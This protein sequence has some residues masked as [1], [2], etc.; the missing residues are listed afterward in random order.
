MLTVIWER[1]DGKLAFL[2]HMND[3]VNEAC[4]ILGIIIRN[5]IYLDTLL[6]YCI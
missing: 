3:K 6:L 4:S 2:D 1:F 5:Y